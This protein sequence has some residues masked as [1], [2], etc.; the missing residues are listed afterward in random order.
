MARTRFLRSSLSPCSREPLRCVLCWGSV[1]PF[2][3]L[4]VH[5]RM[6]NGLDYVFKN[7]F[8]VNLMILMRFMLNYLKNKIVSKLVLVNNSKQYVLPLLLSFI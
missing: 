7:M 6:V 1:E 3:E 4:V 5:F 2:D 8:D